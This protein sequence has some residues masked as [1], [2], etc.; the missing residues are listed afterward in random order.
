[1]KLPLKQGVKVYSEQQHYILCKLKELAQELGRVPMRHELQ[2]LLPRVNIDVLFKTYDNLLACAGLVPQETEKKK[3]PFPPIEDPLT[4]KQI[5]QSQAQRNVIKLN[6]ARKILVIGDVHFPFVNLNALQMVYDFAKKE[7]PDVIVQIGDLDDQYSNSK[8]ARS[9]NIYTPKAE[10]ELAREMAEE[11]WATLKKMSSHADC[12]QLM[13]NHNARVLKRVMEKFPEGEHL[14]ENAMRE[15]MTFEGV[16]TI[17]DPTEE[18]YIND[19][20]FLHGHYS[21]LGAHRDYNRMNVVCGHSHRGGVNYRSYNGETFW[22]LN[23]GFIGDP[24]SKALSYRPQ[25]VHNWTTGLGFIDQY[26]ARFIS[27]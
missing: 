23:A 4:I 19:I 18:L 12:F 15:R 17:H 24:Y 27:F 11:M 10:D 16:T 21:Q 14:I 5:I 6:Y 20:L 3:K 7:K 25:R 1:M 8:F 22:E 26:G 13:G 2:T 9:L